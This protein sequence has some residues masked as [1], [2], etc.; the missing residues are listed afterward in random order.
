MY[1]SVDGGGG[2]CVWLVVGLLWEGETAVTTEGDEV[3][4]AGI[5][6]AFEA[7]WHGWILDG[8]EGERFEL[9]SNDPLMR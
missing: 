2:F 4:L 1:L 8:G 6:A 3:E 5:G 7:Q 9:C